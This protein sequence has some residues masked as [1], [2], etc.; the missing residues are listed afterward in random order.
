M[1]TGTPSD[2]L[3]ESQL[4]LPRRQ[5]KVREIYEVDADRLLIVTTDR[6]SAFDVVLPNGIADKGR[7]LTQMSAFWFERTKGIVPNHL[8]RVIDSTANPD[9]PIALGPEYVGRSM[10]V[11]RAQ[12]VLIEAVV[13]GYLAGS[14]W[15]DYQ[16]TG[17]VCG[18][19][20]PAGMQ[21]SEPFPQPIFTPATKAPV[22]EHDENI[23]YQQAVDLVGEEVANAIK[24]RSIALYVYGLEK[25]RQQGFVIADTK[26][27]F[28]LATNEEGEEEAILIDEALTPDS[29]R[30]WNAS[31]YRSGEHQEAFDKQAL[32]DWLETTGWN[33]E[34]P[35]PSIPEAV[36]EDLRQRYLEAF[37]RIT[38]RELIR[39]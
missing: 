27:E 12:P 10:L 1:T 20:L 15:K 29:W 13:R 11:R 14:G 6:V 28:G 34:A 25:A 3:M 16:Q 5:G 39:P 2:I 7:V 33:K 24:V 22:G 37:E 9:L 38:G 26:F 32:R 35:G 17:E 19:R 4:D 8:I 21:E 18:I 23:S 31:T 36:R 30:F